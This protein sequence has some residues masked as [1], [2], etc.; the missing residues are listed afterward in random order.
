[1]RIDGGGFVPG[2]I[3]NQTEPNLIYAR[4]D[5]GGA[6]RWDEAG[7]RWI[8]LLNWVGWSNAPGQSYHAIYLIGTID[9]V[10]GVYRSDNVGASWVRI[11]D[12]QH[13][14]GNMG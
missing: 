11:N 1:M 7:Q 8:P 9:G 2:I 6:Y 14:Y 3:F 4:T 10:T 13:Q 5:I 12:D